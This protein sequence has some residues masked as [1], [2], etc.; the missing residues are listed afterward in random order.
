MSL[1]PVVYSLMGF[2]TLRTSLIKDR[3]LGNKQ[4]IYK[5]SNLDTE[6][7]NLYSNYLLSQLQQALLYYDEQNIELNIREILNIYSLNTKID[8]DLI[9]IINSSYQN[10]D[11]NTNPIGLKDL[12]QWLNINLATTGI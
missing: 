12:V 7:V 11:S 5:I 2:T 3:T 1:E 9:T 10:L 4:I 8:N 6:I